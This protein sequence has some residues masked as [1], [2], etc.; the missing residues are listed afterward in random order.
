MSSSVK[1][2]ETCPVDRALSVIGGKWTTLIV[3]DLLTGT[4]RF[5]ELR[6]SLRS[7]SATTLSERLQLLEVQGVKERTAYAEM[8]PRVEY[9]LTERG[10]ELASVVNALHAW[11]SRWTS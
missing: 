9:S 1:P 10:K 7:A 8:P 11:G 2:R 5:G 4:K 3:R 6:A